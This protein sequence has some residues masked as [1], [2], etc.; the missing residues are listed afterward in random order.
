MAEV[1]DKERCIALTNAGNRCSRISKNGRFCFQ[2]DESDETIKS[3]SSSDGFIA[4]VQDQLTVQPEQLSGMQRDI[5]QNITQILDQTNGL[6]DSLA[7]LDFSSS[8]DAFRNTVGSTG[9]GA[10]K[11]ALIGG[12]VGSPFGPIGIAAGSSVGGWYGVYKSLEDERA[13][14]ASI[15]DEVPDSATIVSSDHSAIKDVDPV[16]LAIK[17]AVEGDEGDR[18]EWLRSTLTRERDMDSVAEALENLS[19]HQTSEGKGRYYIR[20][21]DTDE[22][23][24]L[25]FGV[26][27][28]T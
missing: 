22:V 10:G 2:H 5:A 27:D 20:D 6:A 19:D 1:D 4:V 21:Q 18:S 7:S 26:P 9:P 13:L 24:L 15:V 25:I 17:S 23:L 14:A 11:G 3:T 16:Q 28:E 8:I 12:V